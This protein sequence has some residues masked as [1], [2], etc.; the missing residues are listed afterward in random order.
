MESWQTIADTRRWAGVTDDEWFKIGEA[1]G[2]SE[3]NALMLLAAIDDDDWITARNSAGLPILR[4]GAA[5]LLFAA[6]KA[7]FEVA[8]MINAPRV[9]PPEQQSAEQ[10]QGAAAGAQQ[11]QPSPQQAAAAT[12]QRQVA[13]GASAGSTQAW[14][15]GAESMARSMADHATPPSDST[16]VATGGTLMP[17]NDTRIMAYTSMEAGIKVNLGLVLNQG[18][19]Q[20]VAMLSLEELSKCRTNASLSRATSLWRCTSSWL[21]RSTP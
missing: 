7:K 2:D 1:M 11:P 18:L 8:T 12:P 17:S 21:Q 16:A 13:A 14:T 4:K 5:N 9:K 19:S 10:Q 20:E 15:S 3:A 6:V